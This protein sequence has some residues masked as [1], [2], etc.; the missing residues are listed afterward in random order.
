[1]EKSRR[2]FILKL[3]GYPIFFIFCVLFFFPMLLPTDQIKN[4]VQREIEANTGYHLE[5]GKTGAGL[6][7]GFVFKD[8]TIS[9]LGADLKNPKASKLKLEELSVNLPVLQLLKG[10]KAISFGLKGFDGEVS[11][12]VGAQETQ[13]QLDISVDGIDLSKLTMVWDALGV[14]FAGRLNGSVSLIFD[15]KDPRKDNGNLR[16]TLTDLNLTEGK[17]MGFELPKLAFGKVQ[18]KIDVKDGKAEVKEF[19]GKGKDI[20]LKGE[21]IASMTPRISST[22]LSMK[23]KFKPA[24]D[25]VQKN[26]SVQPLLFAIQS[27]KDKEGFYSFQVTGP[28][29]RPY[30]NQSR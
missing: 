4:L 25:F 28:L 20:E 24:D 7:G 23:F 6:F 15:T 18:G 3:I 22:G 8:V 12:V 13:Q 14:K 2:I 11:G 19:K 29:E 1:M 21:G 10:R 5:A 16:L 26:Q 17:L 27:A 30:F 9:Q